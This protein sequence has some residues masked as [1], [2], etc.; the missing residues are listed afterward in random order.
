MGKHEKPESDGFPNTVSADTWT[1]V[2]IGAVESDN[3]EEWTIHALRSAENA[4]LN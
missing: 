3:G 1:Q 2:L 4:G